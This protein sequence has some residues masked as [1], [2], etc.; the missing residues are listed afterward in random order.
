MKESFIYFSPKVGV[1]CQEMLGSDAGGWLEV[2]ILP[3]LAAESPQV[4][5]MARPA[6]ARPKG[7]R[8]PQPTRTPLGGNQNRRQPIPERK[9]PYLAPL[10][11]PK[12]PNLPKCIEAESPRAIAS[13]FGNILCQRQHNRTPTP[14]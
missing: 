1:K 10:V 8:R 4:D 6:P 13:R 7:E 2:R 5:C 9:P 3:G 12:L 11:V 14:T